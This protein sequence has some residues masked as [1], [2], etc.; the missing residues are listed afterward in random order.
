MNTML[1][2]MTLIS[3]R[4]ACMT[5]KHEYVFYVEPVQQQRPR[6]TSRGRGF[7]SMYDPKKTSDFKKKIG[8]LANRINKIKCYKPLEGALSVKVSFYRLPP[9]SMSK[10][11]IEKAENKEI[12]PTK[13]PDLSNYIKSL[14]DALN[15]IAWVDDSMNCRMVL[16]KFFSKNPRIEVEVE[17]IGEIEY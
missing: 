11:K 7:I 9:K 5:D 3:S 10:K 14:E 16:E 8:L 13:K 1:L 15:G 2:S 4:S 6:A 17:K 12:L